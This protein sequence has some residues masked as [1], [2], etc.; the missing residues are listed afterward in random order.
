MFD[1][2]KRQNT[3]RISLIMVFKATLLIVLLIFCNSNLLAQMYNDTSPLHNFFKNN[4]DSTIIYNKWSSRY[5]Y[6]NYF[7]IAKKGSSVD[8]FTYKSPYY[9]AQ[10]RYYPAD[11]HHKFMQEEG[12]FISTM[13]DTN[14][15]FLPVYIHYPDRQLCWTQINSFGIWNC[16]E[17]NENISGC[18]IDDDGSDSYYL[19]TKQAIEVKTFYAA[20]FYELCKPGNINRINEIK[21]RKTI[22]K[23]F[24]D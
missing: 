9:K 18:E 24:G 15:Y 2:F 14:R 17:V 22:L 7:I 21:T 16:K 12:R 5:P 6:P 11:L 8:Y 10:G 20:D 4:F 3:S 13:P 1:I 23:F 19:I